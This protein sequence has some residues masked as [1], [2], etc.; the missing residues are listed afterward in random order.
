MRFL[1]PRHAL[2]AVLALLLLLC[3]AMAWGGTATL[4]W[5]APTTNEDGTPLTDLAS[6]NVYAGQAQPLPWVR[7]VPARELRAVLD[8]LAPGVWYF[9]V[10]AKNAAG[11][12]SVHSDTVSLAIGAPVSPSPPTLGPMVVAVVPGLSMSPAYRIT[13]TGA[14]GTTVVGFVPIGKACVG[15]PVFT[16]RGRAYYRV[17]R[18]D[19]VWWATSPTDAV[20][21][22]CS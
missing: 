13:T 16:Y 15:A 1:T 3:V 9:E 2:G 10:T 4:S 21:A 18:G 6:F 7:E 14:R 22:P 5:T 20:A 12:E 17:A 8:G 19:V 11:R